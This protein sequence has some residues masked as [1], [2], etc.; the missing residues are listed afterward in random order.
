MLHTMTT[1]THPKTPAATT[2]AASITSTRHA[3]AEFRAGATAIVPFIVGL[4]PFALVIGTTVAHSGPLVPRLVSTV[5]IMGGS[6]QLAVL[7]GLDRDAALWAVI[8][9]GVVINAR[10][11]AYS[12]SM[13]EAWSGSSRRVRAL[14]AVA[15]LDATFAVL[16]ERRAA[17]GRGAAV[18]AYYAG[19]ALSLCTGWTMLVVAGALTGTVVPGGA[20]AL[21]AP[22]SLTVLLLPRLAKPGG[23]ALVVA[24]ASAALLAAPLPPGVDIVAAV[25]AGLVVSAWRSSRR[26]ATPLERSES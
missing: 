22:L 20:V 15:V 19:A 12:A 9:S 10:L 7:Q 17:G 23:V 24:S 14:A 26:S 4:V 18:R 5:L 25:V 2:S 3:R 11:F 6:A 1:T 8:A 21:A 13:A 16:N